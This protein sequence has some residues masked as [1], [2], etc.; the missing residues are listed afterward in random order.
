MLIWESMHMLSGLQLCN[1]SCSRNRN[2][3]I[4][5]KCFY[6]W[7]LIYRAFLVT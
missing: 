7:I 3:T 2:L 5:F 1:A 6:A 4:Y